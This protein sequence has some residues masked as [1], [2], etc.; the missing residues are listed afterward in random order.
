MI[1]VTDHALMRFLERAGGL[2]VEALRAA[3]AVSLKRAEASALAISAR[4]YTIVADGLR[5]VVE[6]GHL[7]T[8]LD[9]GMK[10]GRLQPEDAER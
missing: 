6:D 4:R 9:A 8:V 7:V 3:I 5:Y 2:D 1:R 10:L